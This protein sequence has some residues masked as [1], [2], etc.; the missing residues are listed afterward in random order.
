MSKS[1]GMAL[2]PFAFECLG[3]SYNGVDQKINT[4]WADVAV[5]QTLNQMQ[6]LGPTSH[7]VTIKGVIFPE[8]FGGQASLEGIKAAADMGTLLMLVSG[9]ALAGSVHGLCAVQSISIENSY[10]N[11]RGT[12]GR[13]S[14]SISLKKKQ[15]VGI[16]GIVSSALSLI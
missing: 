6:F 11:A 13:S 2:G 15:D 14:Y 4:P 3:F 12:A 9:D 10:H 7:E 1:S 8:E 5:A 16:G